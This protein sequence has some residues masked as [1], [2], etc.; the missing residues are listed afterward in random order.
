MSSLFVELKN[1]I[2]N[3]FTNTSFSNTKHQIKIMQ[4]LLKIIEHNSKLL[5]EQQVHNGIIN[6]KYELNYSTCLV[7][8]Y[9]LDTIIELKESLTQMYE[10]NEM[11]EPVKIELDDGV[12]QYFK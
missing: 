2:N 6:A 9:T 1:L 11:S 4:Q 8:E 7:D 10:N 3:K 5:I 12:Q